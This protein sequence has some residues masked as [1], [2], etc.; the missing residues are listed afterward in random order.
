[1]ILV[2]AGGRRHLSWIALG[3]LTAAKSDAPLVTADGDRL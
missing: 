3:N 1:M 2:N